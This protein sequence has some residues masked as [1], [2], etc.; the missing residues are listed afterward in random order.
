MVIFTAIKNPLTLN[1][2]MQMKWS[3]HIVQT[4]SIY[5]LKVSGLHDG[6]NVGSDQFRGQLSMVLVDLTRQHLAVGRTQP[7]HAWYTNNTTQYN[8]L[9]V[10]LF[11]LTCR[12]NIVSPC[13]VHQ[14]YNTLQ[15]ITVVLL[16]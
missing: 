15:Y 3:K 5:Y 16:I 13:L 4:S 6:H 10:V 1:L 12:Q 11:D 7:V 2:G 9:P 8:T 14:Q